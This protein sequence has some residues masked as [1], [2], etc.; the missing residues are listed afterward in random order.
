MVFQLGMTGKF[1]LKEAGIPR[2]KH[3]HVVFS[4]SEDLA[5]HYIDTRRFGR[6]WLFDALD[7]HHPDAAMEAGGM[8][9]LGPEAL[10]MSP[11]HFQSC[12]GSPRPIK[13]LLLDQTRLTGLGNIYCDESLFAARIHPTH[14]SQEIDP[15]QATTLLREIKGVL[16][17]AIRAGGTTFS[18]FENAYGDMGRFRKRLKVYGRQGQPCKRCGNLIERIVLN[19]RGTHI[20]P[21]C[22]PQDP[23]DMPS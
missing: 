16:R 8:G 21:Q 9:R 23:R 4:F 14:A 3:T 6:C 7:P 11:R 12:L 19:G 2:Q 1:L 20:C 15:E 13:S 10:G 17:R 5:L 22:Q 18:D